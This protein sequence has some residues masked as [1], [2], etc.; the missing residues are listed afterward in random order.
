MSEAL[1]NTAAAVPDLM[2]LEP[3]Q[4]AAMREQWLAAGLD[5]QAFD[6]A[7]GALPTPDPAAGAE[8]VGAPITNLKTPAV[9][10]AQAQAMAA[11]LIAAGASEEQVNAALREDG[12]TPA[13]DSRTDEE[14]EFDR[15]FAGA[16]PEAYRIDY[17][18]R[19]PAG[20]DAKTLT[21]A[22]AEVTAWLSEV[23]FPPE[24]GPGVAER[25]MDVGQQCARMTAPERELFK[26]EQEAAF[27]QMAGSEE[28]AEELV[29]FVAATMGHGDPRFWDILANSG[30]LD[31]AGVVMHLAHQGERLAARASGSV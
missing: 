16:A 3:G 17:R 13:A 20:I 7:S 18:D 2:A 28:R 19:L 8:I 9:S 12:F 14:K 11:E 29:E 10:E 31:D 26:R 22:N 25:A 1:D 30:A 15:S 23:G 4:V 5:P 6:V 27:V 21:D 24:I